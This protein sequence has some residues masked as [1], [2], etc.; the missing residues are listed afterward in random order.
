MHP[1]ALDD[2]S[3]TT[4][5]QGPNW[6]EGERVER[7][8][9]NGTRARG[10]TRKGENP[11]RGELE[12]FKLNQRETQDCIDKTALRNDSCTNNGRP[13]V[14]EVSSI[15]GTRESQFDVIKERRSNWH[16]HWCKTYTVSALTTTSDSNYAKRIYWQVE[17]AN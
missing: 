6:R 9:D 14:E 13:F 17:M 8:E 2:K 1:P 3:I 7:D 5:T 10:G 12:R 4:H 11:R 15:D 16:K